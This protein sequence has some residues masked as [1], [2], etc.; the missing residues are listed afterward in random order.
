MRHWSRAVAAI[1]GL[2][3]VSVGAN[4]NPDAYHIVVP[5]HAV[6]AG[7]HLQL[8]LEPK[9]PEGMRVDFSVRSGQQG[10]GLLTD[11]Y[12]APFVIAPGTGP[13]EISVWTLWGRL[14]TTRHNEP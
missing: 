1:L 6:E 8:R 4:P 14:A 5:K 2:L 10:I 7:E 9:P 11:V 12:R 13:V 3:P